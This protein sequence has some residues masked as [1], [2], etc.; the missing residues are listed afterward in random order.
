MLDAIDPC[1]HVFEHDPFQIDR[2]R[3][4][5][6]D[7]LDL[8]CQPINCGWSHGGLQPPSADKG[9]PSEIHHGLI[10]IAKLTAELGLR[11]EYSDDVARYCSWPRHI[12][13]TRAVADD[14]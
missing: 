13:M 5:G 10:G 2:K 7:A 14:D 1:W 12:F 9:V 11:G 8:A 6:C 3:I 4:A